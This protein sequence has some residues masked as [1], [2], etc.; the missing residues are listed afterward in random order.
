MAVRRRSVDITIP[1]HWV[2]RVGVVVLFAASVGLFFIGWRW[3]R[4]LSG[5]CFARS[6]V[7]LYYRSPTGAE[8]H[9][10]RF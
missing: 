9:G 4:R 10:Y 5:L 7:C 8:K 1:R 3:A 6:L 2:C